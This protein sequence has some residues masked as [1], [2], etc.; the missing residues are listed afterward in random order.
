M[1]IFFTP[2]ET[3]KRPGIYQRYE[4]IGTPQLA[5]ATNGICAVLFK[6]QWGPVNQV[7]VL[8]S[9]DQ[10]ATIYGKQDG[11]ET[12]AQLFYGGAKKVIA[13]RVGKNGI[14]GAAT[15]ADT[16]K[17]NVITISLKYP[18][19]R[20]FQYLVRAY[21]GDTKQKEFVLLEDQVI[22]ERFIFPKNPTGSTEAD[23]LLAAMANSAYLNGVKTVNYSGNGEIA[24]VTQGRFSDG[25][26]GMVSAQEYQT[27]LNLLE[28]QRFNTVSFDTI[29]TN[30]TA[31]L[32]SFMNR[33]YQSG[34]MAFAVIGADMGE[35]FE[36][37]L[38]Q[39]ATFN[40]YKIVYV[41][42]GWKDA[43][44]KILAGE[45]AAAR[46]AGMIASIPAN[47]SITHRVISGAVEPIEYLT[48]S[49]YE[50][51]IDHG[52]LVL[53]ANSLDQVWVDSGITSLITLSG[54]DDEGWKK[55]KRAKIRFELMSRASDSV[56]PLIGATPNNEDGRAAIIQVVQGVCNSMIAEEKLLPGACCVLDAPRR[57]RLVFHYCQRY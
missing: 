7:Q 11:Y 40:D 22:L 18:G 6:S 33:I 14:C 26:S 50:D 45:N 35:N 56:A 42:N 44:G 9:L 17:N 54:N 4:N 27:G 8:D 12:I 32:S 28:T 48:N 46:I 10:A 25:S 3:K 21:L 1:G 36:D 16:S 47:E 57:Q 52:M 43:S 37:R 51:C 13:V 34:K 24:S 23:A 55:I 41:G 15:L 49:Q 20:Q 2:G 30:E 19:E 5:G 29:D 39:A 38:K 31:I 53:S